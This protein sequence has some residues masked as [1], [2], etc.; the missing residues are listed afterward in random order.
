LLGEGELGFTGL[1][2]YQ[3]IPILEN[4]GGLEMENV[5]VY[6]IVT[7]NILWLFWHILGLFGIFCGHLVSFIKKKSGNPSVIH[8]TA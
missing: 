8:K 7:C 4:Y 5:L 1:P 2:S 3:K 6:F